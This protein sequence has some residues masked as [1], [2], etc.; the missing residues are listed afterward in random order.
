MVLRYGT[1]QTVVTTYFKELFSASAEP[2]H[3]VQP[4]PGMFPSLMAEQESQLARR[5]SSTDVY[6]ALQ[7]MG[8]FKALRPD[9]FHAI[10]FQRYWD[11]VPND[12]C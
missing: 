3:V 4:L 2:D 12:V 6:E 1:C 10:F 9:K 5:F 11:L 7:T 8:P